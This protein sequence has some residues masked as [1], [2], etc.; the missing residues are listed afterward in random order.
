M[1]FS[2]LPEMLKGSCLYLGILLL[3][4]HCV[5]MVNLEMYKALII[6]QIFP[7]FK[8]ISVSTIMLQGIE[9]GQ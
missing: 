7:F 5:F 6:Y 3:C 1:Q 8:H 9:I 4:G 2:E